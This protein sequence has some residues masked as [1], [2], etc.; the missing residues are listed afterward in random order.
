MNKTQEQAEQ[1]SEDQGVVAEIK[2]SMTVDKEVPIDK[3]VPGATF[4]LVALSYLV[5]LIIVAFVL[6]AVFWSFSGS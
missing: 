5:I 6:A 2:Q 3:K 4:S 1:P